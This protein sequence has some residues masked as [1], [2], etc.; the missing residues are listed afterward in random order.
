MVPDEWDYDGHDVTVQ[1]KTQSVIYRLRAQARQ[2]LLSPLPPCT[3]VTVIEPQA[4]GL[5]LCSSL[6]ASPVPSLSRPP[7]SCEGP[8]HSSGFTGDW[9][10]RQAGLAAA[11]ICLVY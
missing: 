11:V 9:S 8:P 5:G 7:E 6:L 2:D 1:L 4:S 3:D 10:G